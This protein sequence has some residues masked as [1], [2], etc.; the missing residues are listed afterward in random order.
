MNVLESA[1]AVE[2]SVWSTGV[3]GFSTTLLWVQSRRRL[4]L[5]KTAFRMCAGER[6]RLEAL[7]EDLRS[8]FQR[9]RRAAQAPVRA[10]RCAPGVA[11][12]EILN[13]IP[14]YN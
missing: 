13:R 7:S 5:T 9:N 4:A 11:G 3:D 14:P 2:D 1:C 10:F 8:C 6:L 12:D